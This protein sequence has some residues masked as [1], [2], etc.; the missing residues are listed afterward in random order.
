MIG[1]LGGPNESYLD[2][3]PGDHT[4]VVF[5]HRNKK[6]IW[7][8]MIP[9]ALTDYNKNSSK[10]WPLA[11]SEFDKL[12][13]AIDKAYMGDL[14]CLYT[15]DTAMGFHY[16]VYLTFLLAGQAFEAINYHCGPA[17]LRAVGARKQIDYQSKLKEFRAYL[18]A[19]VQTTKFLQCVLSSTVFKRHIGVWTCDGESLHFLL[20]K[21][22]EKKESLAFGKER[23]ILSRTKVGPSKESP[24]EDDQD[25]DDDSPEVCKS[26]C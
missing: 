11:I 18:G 15:K 7:E 17:G 6:F 5:L 1:E 8:D 3:G 26:I 24:S 13:E 20:P 10:Q 21:W 4:L 19:A 23:G 25:N 16:L 12:R 22:S 14:K 9:L 2:R